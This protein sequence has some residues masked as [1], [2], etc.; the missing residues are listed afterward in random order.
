MWFALPVLPTLVPVAVLLV[1]PSG[2][3]GRI[4]PCVAFG[5]LVTAYLG[6]TVAR[7]GVAVEEN[8]N[9]LTYSVGLHRAVA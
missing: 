7:H 9:A 6:A 8:A 2:R 3:R 1:E 5:V 4:V